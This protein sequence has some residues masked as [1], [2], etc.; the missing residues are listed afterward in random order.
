MT[1]GEQVVRF[2][3]A[4]TDETFIAELESRLGKAVST[5]EAVSARIAVVETV[6]EELIDRHATYMAL[7]LNVLTLQVEELDA[8]IVR[9][10]VRL[11]TLKN[12]EQRKTALLDRGALPKLEV[13]SATSMVAEQEAL[14]DEL[15]ATR[16][17]RQLK[18]K[19]IGDGV[20]IG[21]EGMDTPYTQQ[22]LDEI[23]LRLAALYDDLADQAAER[24]AV[25]RLLIE[26]RA[27]FQKENAIT[28]TSPVSGIVWRSSGQIGRPVLPGDDVVEI[29]NCDA[30]FLE[31]YLPETTFGSLE[32]GDVAEIRLTGDERHFKAP[33][34]SILGHGARFD[35]PNLAA[36]DNSPKK[37]MMRVIVALGSEHLAFEGT[38]FCHVGRTA[39][40]SFPRDLSAIDQVLMSLR[41]ASSA[42]S[43]FWTTA[44]DAPGNT[45]S[46][47]S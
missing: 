21:P 31:A 6:R 37:G 35:H 16:A 33:V 14:I 15:I 47:R 22:R 13:V 46:Q 4:H 39:L 2:R 3:E 38:N 1:S 45:P 30:R 23:A 8:E 5:E 20:I 32:V 19:A 18:L 26:E 42:L 24:R 36:Q 34:T 10:Q 40:V 44:S 7:Q 9:A 17:V 11:Q 41:K 25:E 29:L 27:I 28:L 12:D 43:S